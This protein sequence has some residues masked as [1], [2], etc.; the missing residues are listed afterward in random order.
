MK[1]LEK[2]DEIILPKAPKLSSKK[3]DCINISPLVLPS[4]QLNVKEV[5]WEKNFEDW[6]IKNEN[7]NSTQNNQKKMILRRPMTIKNILKL[8]GVK[9]K[10]EDFSKTKKAKDCYSIRI[11]VRSIINLNSPFINSYQ[12]N[13]SSE[14]N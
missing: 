5:N 2:K 1:A 4:P 3:L 7:P 11:D 13:S 8:S 10:F 14:A 9:Y 12:I 6:C